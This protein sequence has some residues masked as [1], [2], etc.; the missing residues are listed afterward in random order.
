MLGVTIIYL[1]LNSK[2]WNSRSEEVKIIMFHRSQWNERSNEFAYQS[3]GW[4]NS[5]KH[6]INW[7]PDL[8]GGKC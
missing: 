7:R 1:K 4:E 6:L 5:T 8:N 3:E 2:K